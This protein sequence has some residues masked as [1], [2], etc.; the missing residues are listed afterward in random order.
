MVHHSAHDNEEFRI[1]SCIEKWEALNTLK[2]IK[3]RH[4]EY[5]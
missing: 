3:Y 2:K 4:E 5:N 1:K